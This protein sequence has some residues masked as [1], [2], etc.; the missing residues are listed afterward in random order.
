MLCSKE[1]NP[2]SYR[3]ESLNKSI[4]PNG[5]ETHLRFAA[6]SIKEKKNKR[7]GQS[8]KTKIA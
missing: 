3:M 6:V 5:N 1:S 7:R 4:N 2:S 8:Y